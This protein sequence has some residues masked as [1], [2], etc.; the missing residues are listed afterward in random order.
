MSLYGVLDS[1]RTFSPAFPRLIFVNADI[2]DTA[3]KEAAAY[4]AEVVRARTG[5][6]RRDVRF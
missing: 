2:E 3:I 5:R 4:R 6:A 1:A